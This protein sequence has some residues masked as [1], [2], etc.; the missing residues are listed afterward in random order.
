MRWTK[1]IG[2][3]ALML[4][5]TIAP[6]RLLA[7][8]R[9]LDVVP[10]HWVDI[11]GDKGVTA[12]YGDW[13]PNGDRL[14]RAVGETYVRKG[15]ISFWKSKDVDQYR[16]LH[17]ARKYVFAFFRHDIGLPNEKDFRYKF[18]FIAHVDRSK[19]RWESKGPEAPYS[20]DFYKC[21]I[22]LTRRGESSEFQKRWALTDAHWT[23]SNEELIA[24]WDRYEP[25]NPRLGKSKPE[26]LRPLG[27][28]WWSDGYYLMRR[29]TP[30]PKRSEGV[31]LPRYLHI[32]RE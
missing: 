20:M 16:V 30:K 4:A 25:C 17:Q 10:E 26:K 21:G 2:L 6:A 3:V 24:L 12:F 29:G 5:G 1:A 9:L 31:E 18:L 23:W 14:L 32:L 7:D 27:E 13:Q 11:P 15:R 28:N 19:D 22:G 8:D